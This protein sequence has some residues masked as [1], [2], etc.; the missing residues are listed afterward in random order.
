MQKSI[1][2]SNSFK[3]AIKTALF[4]EESPILIIFLF[5][6]LEL[7]MGKDFMINS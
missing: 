7:V 3:S 6:S 5:P 2:W 4:S 1:F